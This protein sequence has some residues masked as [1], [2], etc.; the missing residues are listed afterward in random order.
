MSN[1]KYFS[2]KRLVSLLVLALLCSVE[3]V[4]A[5][6][7]CLKEWGPASVYS[8]DSCTIKVPLSNDPSSFEVKGFSWDVKKENLSFDLRMTNPLS[9][10]GLK[11]TFYKK[12]VPAASYTL[13]L[14]TDPEYNI[15]Q[16]DLVTPLSIPRSSLV[17][18][19]PIE[20]VDNLDKMTVYMATKRSGEGDLSLEILSVK[21]D[22]REAKKGL[23]SI[24]FDDGY[25]SN[26]LA[27]KIMRPLGL[28][29]TAYLIPS[30]LGEERHLTSIQAKKMKAWGWSLSTHLAIPVTGLPD[31]KSVVAKAKEAIIKLGDPIGAEHFALP[32]G[33]YNQRSLGILKN[34]FSSIR[35][36]GGLFETLPVNDKTRLKTFNVLPNMKPQY[37]FEQCKKAIENGDWIILMFH[38]LDQPKQ[39]ELNYSSED[40][41]TLMKLLAP[42]K[43]SVKTVSEVLSS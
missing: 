21:K 34:N 38:Y 24:T 37:V 23:V 36:A 6:L 40:Y 41:K 22:S 42:V 29:G 2:Y 31:L 18:T 15:L 8:G 20:S 10:Q 39:G 35:L 7:D 43:D 11:F 19:Q 5:K 4:S 33:K 9:L 16:N 14:Y 26:F 12:G 27:A 25:F 28:K 13:P 17:W 30:V 32:L 3:N 1:R